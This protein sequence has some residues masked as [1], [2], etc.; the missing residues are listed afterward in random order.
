MANDPRTMSVADIYRH[1]RTLQCDE[2]RADNLVR[3]FHRAALFLVAKIENEGWKWRS[4]YL[5]EHAGCALGAKFTNTI[6][7]YINELLFRQHPHLRTYDE[8]PDNNPDLFR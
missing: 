5:R 3:L 2:R 1:L 8:N 7:P 4:N 6:S